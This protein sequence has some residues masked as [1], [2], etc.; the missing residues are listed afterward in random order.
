MNNIKFNNAQQSKNFTLLLRIQEYFDK[1]ACFHI[2]IQGK[3]KMQN[4]KRKVRRA[5]RYEIVEGR[6]EGRK[7]GRG[8]GKTYKSQF[9]YLK[10]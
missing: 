8:G 10:S 6:Q 5:R 4:M 2:A 9:L 1:R 3:G 7:E